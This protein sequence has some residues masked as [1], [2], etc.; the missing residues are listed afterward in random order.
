MLGSRVALVLSRL[1]RLRIRNA[2]FQSKDKQRNDWPSGSWIP[3]Q[4]LFKPDGKRPV[5]HLLSR[6][7]TIPHSRLMSIGC[8]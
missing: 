6:P 4:Q 8:E 5:F 3:R 2:K 1:E 7:M